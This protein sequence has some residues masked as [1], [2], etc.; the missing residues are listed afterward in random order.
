M[1]RLL[2]RPTWRSATWTAPTWWEAR[3]LTCASTRSS[4]ATTRCVCTFTGLT[5]A[6]TAI[7]SQ[8]DVTQQHYALWATAVDMI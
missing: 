1:M 6:R 3:S 2:L 5:L 4:L 8:P 7:T